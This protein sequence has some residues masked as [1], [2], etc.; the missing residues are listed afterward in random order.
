MFHDFYVQPMNQVY[1][2]TIAIHLIWTVAM[3][4]LRGKARRIVGIVGACI[5]IILILMFTVLGRGSESVKEISL[6]PF[7]TFKNAK[8]QSE[9]YRTMFMNILLF[10]PLGLSLPYS[11][12]GKIKHKAVLTILFGT[13]LSITIEATQ[14]VFSLGKC[15]TDDVLMNTFGM[16]IGVTSFLIFKIVNKLAENKTNSFD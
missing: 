9:L 2:E 3:F 12:P 15:E 11:L 5:A 8:E 7:I 6:I 13:V 10:L 14:Y 1:I 16:M 4:M